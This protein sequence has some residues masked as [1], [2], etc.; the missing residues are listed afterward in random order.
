MLGIVAGRPRN[1]EPTRKV[2]PR[3]HPKAFAQLEKLAEIG[4][5]GSTATDVARY[6]ITRGLD[7]L[8]RAGVLKAPE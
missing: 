8:I 4:T 7:D 1:E 5:Y 6:L 3:L 2:E